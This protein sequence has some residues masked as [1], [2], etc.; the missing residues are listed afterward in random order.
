MAEPES[1][2]FPLPPEWHK[3]HYPDENM[4]IRQA[5]ETIRSLFLGY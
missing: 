2:M 3:E 1:R 4:S 5:W